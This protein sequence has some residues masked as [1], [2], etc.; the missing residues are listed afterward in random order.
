[1]DVPIFRLDRHSLPEPHIFTDGPQVSLEIMRG[2]V[3]QRIRQVRTRVFLI[4]AASDCD[5]VLGDLQFP[6][7]Y[8][9]LFVSGSQV[10]IR[11]LGAGPELIVCGQHVESAELFHGDL[12]GFGPFELRVRIDEPLLSRRDATGMAAACRMDGGD[13]SGSASEE[14]RALLADIRRALADQ[15]SSVSWGERNASVS[16]SFRYQATA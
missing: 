2:R 7:A 4:G 6:E 9:Y 5:L 13:E 8:A 1:M 16:A 12:V 15:P 3:Q 10:T 11:R 14:V